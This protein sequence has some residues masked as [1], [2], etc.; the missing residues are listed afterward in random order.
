MSDHAVLVLEVDVCLDGDIEVHT[1]PALDGED[2]DASGVNLPIYFLEGSSMPERN[3]I[4]VVRRTH[5]IVR[6]LFYPEQD[7]YYYELVK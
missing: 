7:Y 5:R 3:S 4:I 6:N 1:S 2:P